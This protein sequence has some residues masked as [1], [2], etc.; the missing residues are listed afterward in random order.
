MSNSIANS[1]AV[2]FRFRL[3]GQHIDY[4]E[5]NHA[6]GATLALLERTLTN[7]F[8]FVPT[9]KN[10]ALGILSMRKITDLLEILNNAE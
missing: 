7:N 9:R 2:Q 4:V 10:M 6:E 1:T 8:V 3:T 5:V